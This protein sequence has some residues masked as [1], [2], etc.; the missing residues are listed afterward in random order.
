MRDQDPFQSSIRVIIRNVHRDS[1]FLQNLQSYSTC[2]QTLRNSKKTIITDF[3]G[4]VEQ[5]IQTGYVGCNRI[6]VQSNLAGGVINRR[7]ELLGDVIAAMPFVDLRK[8]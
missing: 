2:W 5:S 1:A 6:A 8:T 3:I 4:S 7:P